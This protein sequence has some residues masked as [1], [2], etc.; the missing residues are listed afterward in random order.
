M[1]QTYVAIDATSGAE[2]GDG[3][4]HGDVEREEDREDRRENSDGKTHF[5]IACSCKNGLRR[6]ERKGK[7][8]RGYEELLQM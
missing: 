7:V 8:K 1:L 6:I 5:R 2:L 3:V 4:R